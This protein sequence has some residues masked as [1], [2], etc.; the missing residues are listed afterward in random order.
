Y[1]GAA[2]GPIPQAAPH[3]NPVMSTVTGNALLTS[4][5]L[6]GACANSSPRP[7]EAPAPSAA[8]A[9]TTSVATANAP[10]PST[11]TMAVGSSTATGNAVG[12]A[13]TEAEGKT[14]AG[15]PAVV[16]DNNVNP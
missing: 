16:A 7:D 8:I 4:L 14:D 12:D 15:S 1:D 5:L 2:S 6:L 9:V 13:G 3:K 11:S 10:L